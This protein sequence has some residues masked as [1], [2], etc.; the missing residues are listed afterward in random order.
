[1]AINKQSR[2][3]LNYEWIAKYKDGTELRQFDDAADLECTFGDVKTEEVAQFILEK[4]DRSKTF[5]VDLLTGLFLFNGSPVEQID[6]NGKIQPLGKRLLEGAQVKLIYFRR[7]QRTI[8]AVTAEGFLAS[9]YHFIGWNGMVNG[10]Y[11]KHEIAISN[12]SDEIVVPPK[13]SFTPL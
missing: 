2:E 12:N 11:E 3:E 13:E 10:K 7:V 4:K 8:N 1:M 9:I 5:G 6:V